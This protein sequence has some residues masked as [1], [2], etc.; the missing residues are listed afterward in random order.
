MLYIEIIS[1][2]L[3]RVTQVPLDTLAHYPFAMGLLL[4]DFHISELE[5]LDKPCGKV[6][7]EPA[8]IRSSVDNYGHWANSS[9]IHGWKIDT[10]NQIGFIRLIII[11]IV[12]S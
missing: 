1:S 4:G 2:V 6:R 7:I 12:F 11:C 9:Y 8:A 3:W 5:R 10:A